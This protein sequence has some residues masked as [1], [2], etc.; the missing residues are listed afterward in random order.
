MIQINENLWKPSLF[1]FHVERSPTILCLL[2]R[3]GQDVAPCSA[4][5]A[6]VAEEGGTL[7]LGGLG[8]MELPWEATS[9]SGDKS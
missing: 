6:G 9:G 1:S 5:L 7:A 4:I 8:L 3:T 2:M